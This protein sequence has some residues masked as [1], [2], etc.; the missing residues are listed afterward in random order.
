MSDESHEV[1]WFSPAETDGLPM[2]S[3]IRRRLADWRSGKIPMV[4]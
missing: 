2:V 3:N 1:A 4:R